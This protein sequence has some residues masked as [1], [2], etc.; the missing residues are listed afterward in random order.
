MFLL[1]FIKLCFSFISTESRIAHCRQRFGLINKSNYVTIPFSTFLLLLFLRKRGRGILLLLLLLAFGMKKKTVGNK[2]V[3]HRNI[4]MF[5][6]IL[7]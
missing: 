7:C 3:Q 1:L 5:P 4:G 2:V 6:L